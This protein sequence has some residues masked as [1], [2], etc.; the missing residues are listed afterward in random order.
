MN[1][2]IFPAE[3]VEEFRSAMLSESLETAGFVFAQPVHLPT[4]IRFLAERKFVAPPDA[5]LERSGH[6]IVLRPEYLAYIYKIART[7]NR[8]VFTAHTHPWRGSVGPSEVDI[9]GERLSIPALFRLVPNARHGRLILGHEAMH[10]AL[11]REDGND[12]DVKVWSVGSNLTELTTLDTPDNDVRYQR[13]VLAFGSEGQ[14]RIKR[15]RVSIVGLGGTGSQVAQYLAYLGVK[16]FDLVDPDTIDPT[17]L[18]RLVGALPTDVGL[19][20]VEVA[21]RMIKAINPAASIEARTES[22]LLNS[23]ARSLTGADLIFCCTDSH[24]SRAILTQLAYQYLIPVLDLG[25]RI[26]SAD[27]QV[28][29]VYGRAQMLSPGLPCLVCTNVLDPAQVRRDLMNDFERQRDPYISGAQVQQP[30]VVTLNGILSALASTMFLASVTGL[31]FRARYQIYRA[32]NG[33]VRAIH[34]VP[35]ADCVICSNSGA[36]G[37]GDTWTLPGRLS[38]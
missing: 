36:L 1:R 34:A 26:E 4:G 9:E 33:T 20:K 16:N 18:N 27:G 23:I 6:R 29:D 10:C 11:Y 19:P 15:L 30:A 5:Y 3:A 31:P 17:N 7:T 24:G 35:E 21:R 8:S 25:I 13:Q 28:N 37:R 14:R 22:V 38:P 12:E 2:L 32:K